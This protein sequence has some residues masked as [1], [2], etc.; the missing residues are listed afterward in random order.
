VRELCDICPLRQVSRC[1]AA[2]RTPTAGEIRELAAS[3]PHTE[4]L[5][6]IDIT[7]R[8]AVVAGLPHEQPRYFLQHAL[9]YQVHD[10]RHPHLARQHG[11]AAI[12]WKDGAL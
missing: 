2:H 11:R 12:G 9:G 5:E 10:E 3:V 6:I 8:A 7:R 4:D 1:R